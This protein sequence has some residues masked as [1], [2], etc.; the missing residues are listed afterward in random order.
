[1]IPDDSLYDLAAHAAIYNRDDPACQLRYRFLTLLRDD[2]LYPFMES[3]FR[4]VQYRLWQ[5]TGQNGLGVDGEY[6]GQ[7]GPKGPGFLS[8]YDR[9]DPEA[10][11]TLRAYEEVMTY[12]R[13]KWAEAGG[14]GTPVPLGQYFGWEGES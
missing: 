3:E 5:L 8:L 14:S 11:H 12:L 13:E 1:M 9:F 4:M 2:P 6:G 10:R 7:W